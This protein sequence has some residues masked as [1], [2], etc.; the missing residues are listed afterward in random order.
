[1]KKTMNIA[2]GTGKVV[3]ALMTGIL[4]PILIWVAFGVAMNQKLRKLSAERK[5]APAIGEAL[6]T[7]QV[8]T[9]GKK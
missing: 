3:L 4:M 6:A 2:I 9:T 5:V 7:G 8:A 1:M